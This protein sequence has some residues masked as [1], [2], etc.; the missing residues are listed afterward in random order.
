MTGGGGEAKSTN[1]VQIFGN[2]FISFIG[3]GVL[4]LPYAFKEVRL[5]TAFLHLFDDFL[6]QKDGCYAII[7]VVIRKF[8]MGQIMVFRKSPFFQKFQIK[9]NSKYLSQKLIYS[10]ECLNS[11]KSGGGGGGMRPS[12]CTILLS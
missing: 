10:S 8:C 7:E 11:S 3:A 1:A 12:P 4:G 6:F 2:V 5:F 9:K